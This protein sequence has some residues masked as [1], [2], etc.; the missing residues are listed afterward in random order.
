[1]KVESEKL[2]TLGINA[3]VVDDEESFKSMLEKMKT[4]LKKINRI[5]VDF[6]GI[7]LSKDGRVC[8]GQFHVAETTDVYIV[9]FIK[10]SNPFTFCDSG[11]GDL[12][13]SFD[14][15]KVFFD[16]RNDM[17]A[18]CNQF[19]AQVNNVICL[20]LS[21]V[22]FRRYSR[23]LTVKFI[24]GLGKVMDNYIKFNSNKKV[25]TEI[26]TNGK[27]L[28]YPEHGG[29]FDRFLERPLQT[30]IVEYCVVDVFYFDQLLAILYNPLGPNVKQ[31]VLAESTKRLVDYQTSGYKP[32]S[33]DK[34]YAPSF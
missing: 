25:I 1:M 18:I 16:P 3:F 14:Y 4:D 6:E 31:R 23:K 27:F 12:M 11:L 34:K 8:L 33:S 13:K 17:D 29:S 19:N 9:D 24:M 20:Q 15:V 2:Q 7:D 28:F 32:T 5:N 21:E 30:N 10:I 22:A 26:K